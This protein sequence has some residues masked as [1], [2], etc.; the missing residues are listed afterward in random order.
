MKIVKFA[1]IAIVALMFIGLF[2]DDDKPS[3]VAQVTTSAPATP[4]PAPP[5]PTPPAAPERPTVD[6]PDKYGDDPVLDALWDR[7]EKADYE[8]CEDLYWDSPLHSEY[9]AFAL[10][11][12]NMMDE[13]L[14]EEQLSELIGADFL[15][16]LVWDQT[17]QQGRDEL[18]LGYKLLGRGAGA[19]VAESSGGTVTADEAY[20]WLRRKCQ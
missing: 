1:A 5:A 14:T 9:E 7:C 17:D 3:E 4:A 12:L 15:M 8:A 18:C 13:A 11:S 2:A 20:D 19:I 10:S 16:D 6:G